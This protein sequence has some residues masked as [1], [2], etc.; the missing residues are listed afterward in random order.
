MSLTGDRAYSFNRWPPGLAPGFCL[1]GACFV[2]FALWMVVRE[3]SFESRAQLVDGQVVRF[4]QRK[5]PHQGIVAAPVFRIAPDG[6][7][8]AV[9]VES[10][11][12]SN[13][14]RWN[15]GDRARVFYDP[16]RPNQVVADTWFD[17]WILQAIFAMGGAIFFAGLYE[18]STRGGALRK[19]GQ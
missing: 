16:A 11:L 1:F 5:D 13:P 15:I 18:L 7:A 17:R 9:D 12:A 2:A 4:V 8:K 10:F 19:V 3:I 14:R 6:G